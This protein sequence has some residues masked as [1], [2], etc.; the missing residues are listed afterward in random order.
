MHLP[1][2]E[3]WLE[4]ARHEGEPCVTLAIPRHEDDAIGLVAQRKLRNAVGEVEERLETMGV[5]ADRRERI[6][7]LAREHLQG[8]GLSVQGRTLLFLLSEER[9]EML[10]LGAALAQRVEVS[11]HFVLS[12]LLAARQ[13]PECWHALTV[14][15]D[16]ARLVR[17]IAGT[18]HQVD[19]PL[20]RADRA[21]ANAERELPNY[22]GDR[23]AHRIA[24]PG[25]GAPAVH[26]QGFGD[27]HVDD[28]E[29]RAWH[30]EVVAALDKALGQDHAPLVLIAAPAH[31]GGLRSLIRGRDL[32]TVSR[33]PSGLDDAGLRD[34]A[35]SVLDVV[36]D[37]PSEAERQAFHDANRTTTDLKQALEDARMGR[38]QLLFWDPSADVR[39]VDGE[40]PDGAPDLV[41]EIVR[42]TA[43]HGGQ[44]VPVPA[45]RQPGSGKT[46]VAAALRW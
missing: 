16:Q 4:L 38:I 29:R 10:D 9:S 17:F 40:A 37:E 3:T 22:R 28:I 35:L 30:R 34:L 8:Q 13:E 24:S 31:V 33:H 25:P 44:A 39:H 1:P 15:D 18:P 41:D 43:L 2:R 19:L 36:K 21:A 42:Q 23:H 26:G 7:S 27:E 45:A 5:E 20:E 6:L 12:D 46:P 11:D 14:T 32:R